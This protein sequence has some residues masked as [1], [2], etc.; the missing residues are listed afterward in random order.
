MGKFIK[1]WCRLTQLEE[2]RYPWR[3]YIMLRQ[4]YESGRTTWATHVKMLLFNYGFRCVWL[5]S[6]VGDIDMFMTIFTQRLK[7]CCKQNIFEFI[8]TS[9]KA[10]TYKLYKSALNPEKYLSIP[11]SYPYKKLLSNFRCSAHSLMIERGWLMNIDRIYRYC[12]YCLLR[13]NEVIKDEVHFLL[14]CPQYNM[15]R[16]IHFKQE[17]LSCRPSNDLYIR[18]MSDPAP[19]SIYS[20]CRFL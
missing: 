6:H 16:Q 2:H 17:W 18:I 10:M 8:N 11:L 4:L 15:L 5:N 19:S 7:D 13:N 20:L 3:C 1:Y 9:P 14:I 12:R